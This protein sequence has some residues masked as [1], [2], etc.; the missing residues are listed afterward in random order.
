IQHWETVMAWLG[1]PVAIKTDNGPCFT[2]QATQDWCQKW[3]IQLK[4][5]IPYNSTGQAIIER[6]H[7]T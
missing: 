6:A 3:A 2:A 4:H 7:R 1:K 5:S